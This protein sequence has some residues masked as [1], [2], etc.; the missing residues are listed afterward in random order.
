MWFVPIYDTKHDFCLVG[1]W[2]L[3]S[4]SPSPSLSPPPPPPFLLSS[5][6]FSSSVLCFVCLF[7][8]VF[9]IRFLYISLA[10]LEL[11]L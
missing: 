6:S 1:G 5:S 4:S 7:V 3:S 9:Q 2:W 11:T 10:V 8:S